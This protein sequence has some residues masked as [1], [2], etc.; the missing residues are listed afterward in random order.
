MT[1]IV[2]CNQPLTRNIFQGE[3]GIPMDELSSTSCSPLTMVLSYARKL[4][5]RD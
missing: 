3:C 5:M 4:W 1:E 2:L